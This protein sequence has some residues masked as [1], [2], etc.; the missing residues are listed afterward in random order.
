MQPV[1][2]EIK[3]LFSTF[4]KAEVKTIYKLPQSGSDREYYRIESSN[5]NYIATH[6]RHIKE[7]K[8]FLYFSKHFK[9]CGCPVPEIYSVNEQQTIYIQQDFGDTSLLNVLEE[10]GYTT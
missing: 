3:K 4:S 6:N 7:N 2:E 8:T 10:K 5:G 1:I 9:S